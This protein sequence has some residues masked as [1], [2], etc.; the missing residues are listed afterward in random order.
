MRL[1]RK[2]DDNVA[3][4]AVTRNLGYVENG[5]EHRDRRRHPSTTLKFEM[6][7]EHWEAKV[8][9]DDITIHG[10]DECRELFGL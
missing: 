5:H 4:L 2:F 7:R 1:R 10:V 8:R 9:R 6:S 3:S